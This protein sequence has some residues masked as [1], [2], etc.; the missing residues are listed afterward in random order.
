MQPLSPNIIIIFI[1]YGNH[2]HHDHPG[3]HLDLDL[4]LR[5][6][7]SVLQ[8]LPFANGFNIEEARRTDDEILLI[9][10]QEISLIRQRKD[11]FLLQTICFPLKLLLSIP[12]LRLNGIDRPILRLALLNLSMC[13]SIVGLHC[14]LTF[15]DF[16]LAN[17]PF[18]A[19]SWVVDA[20]QG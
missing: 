4:Q 1:P 9:H 15:S 14:H 3:H 8:I 2:D 19:L 20:E 7:I 12:I 18:Y 5:E 6:A 13:S 10:N 11:L 17:E 16:S